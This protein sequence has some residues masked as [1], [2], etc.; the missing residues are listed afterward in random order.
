MSKQQKSDGEKTYTYKDYFELNYGCKVDGNEPL[1]CSI[2][3]SKRAGEAR[4]Q[5]CLLPPSLCHRLG[6]SED[7]DRNGQTKQAMVK[8]CKVTPSDGLDFAKLFVNQIASVMES[9]EF[10]ISIERN[11]IK[12]KGKV[13][14]KAVIQFNDDTKY[15][16]GDRH[17]WRAPQ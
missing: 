4:T 17:D 16:P 7:Q 11:P 6:L 13:F 15:L 8:T 12:T 9:P 1:L 14:K 5:E 10:P 2:R 3:T